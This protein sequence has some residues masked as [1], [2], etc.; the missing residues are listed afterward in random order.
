MGQRTPATLYRA[1]RR[2]WPDLPLD[3]ARFCAFV[4]G[5]GSEIDPARAADLYLACAS[6]AALPAALAAF[7]TYLLHPLDGALKRTGA[8]PELIDEVKQTLRVRLLVGD[9]PGL[10][11][12]RG[13]GELRGWVRIIAV[14][15]AVHLRRRQRRQVPIADALKDAA[16]EDPELKW[17]RQRYQLEFKQALKDAFA[18]LTRAERSVLRL[19]FLDGL[20]LD[21]VARYLRV[22]RAT[23]ARRL[24]QAKAALSEHTRHALEARLSV[25]AAE[26]DSLFR[27][28]VPRIEITLRRLLT[29]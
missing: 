5:L 9:P 10:S 24:A 26:L 11:A 23:A 12:Y 29:P 19:Q 21:Q 2:A 16:D 6:I 22:H 18:R 4:T 27:M 14:R 17:L 15:E 8:S 20:T 28:L 25:P 3:E 1:G 13:V 7:E